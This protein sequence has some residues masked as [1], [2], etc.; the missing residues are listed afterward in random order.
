[1][2]TLRTAL[3]IALWILA[4]AG[5]TGA[6]ESE[7]AE[8]GRART[9]A[10]L[11]EIRGSGD[12]GLE[13]WLNEGDQKSVRIGESLAFHFRTKRP[14]H[15]TALHVDA[16]GTVTVL[17][18]GSSR[19]FA[20]PGR[21]QSFPPARSGHRLVAEPPL[22]SEV[23]IAIATVE[24]LPDDLFGDGTGLISVEASQAP[25]MVRR[26]V[27]Y[28]SIL[29]EGTVDTARFSH[30]VLPE[31]SGRSHS[32]DEIVR[33]FTTQTRSLH[34]EGLDFDIRF[35]FGSAKL[36]EGARKELDE[37]GNALVHPAMANRRFEIGGH[38]DDVGRASYN[39][40]LS[41]QRASSAR[42]YLIEHFE[43]EPARVAAVGYGESKPMENATSPEARAANRR[44]V[45]EQL[46]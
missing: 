35:E 11:E 19:S 10:T 26:L 30:T 28:V 22:G 44:V 23:V 45:L 24:A 17:H 9:L 3:L 2:K 18:D 43:I 29:P 6:A 14:A 40:W 42:A 39:Q 33:H 4:A 37:V 41:E 36:T 5:P 34:R 13:A 8:W 38:T 46:P 12:L 16:S 7:A 31:K 27:D 1:M 20:Q 32:K 15:L 21:V 25:H